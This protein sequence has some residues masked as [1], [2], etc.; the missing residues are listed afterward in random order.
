MPKF[1]TPDEIQ[2]GMELAEPV[3]N[4]FGQVLLSSNLKLQTKHTVILKTWGIQTIQIISDNDV[5]KID[6]SALEEAREKL[7][8]RMKWSPRNANEEDLVEMALNRI[9]EIKLQ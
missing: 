3:K 5:T 2:E 7:S 1:I 4:K 8:H 6:E 9:L